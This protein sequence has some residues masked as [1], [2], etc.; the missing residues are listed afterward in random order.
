MEF[1]IVAMFRDKDGTMQISSVYGPFSSKTAAEI[2]KDD[3]EFPS[4]EWAYIKPIHF[5]VKHE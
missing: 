2:I 1:C 3:M 5:P 4:P